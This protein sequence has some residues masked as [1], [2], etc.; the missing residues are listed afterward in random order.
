MHDEF[1]PKKK[2][3]SKQKILIGIKIQLKFECN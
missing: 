3:I 2:Q 1:S